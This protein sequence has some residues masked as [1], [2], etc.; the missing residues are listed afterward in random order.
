MPARK[1]AKQ[2][3]TNIMGSND[4]KKILVSHMIKLQ[5]LHNQSECLNS[6]Q[7]FDIYS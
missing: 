3:A 5:K 2:T 4:L 1:Q 6:Y 7:G